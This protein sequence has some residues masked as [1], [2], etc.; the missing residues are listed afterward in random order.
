MTSTENGR[1]GTWHGA[2]AARA[3]KTRS[4]DASPVFGL[5]RR[6]TADR[7]RRRHR[8]VRELVEAPAGRALLPQAESSARERGLDRAD[9]RKLEHL[10]SEIVG[11]ACAGQRLPKHAMLGLDA[12]QLGRVARKRRSPRGRTD[13][14]A[15]QVRI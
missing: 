15:E 14:D 10:E 5:R 13:R 3:L 9:G 12:A 11:R 4:R 8:W 7:D 1:S 6:V 2:C